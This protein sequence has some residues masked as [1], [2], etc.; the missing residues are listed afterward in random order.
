[1]AQKITKKELTQPDAFQLALT[2]FSDFASENKPKIYIS[3]GI[4]LLII[5]LSAGLYLYKANNEKN[6]QALFIKAHLA[7]LKSRSAESPG[8]PNSTKL[9]Q[10][11]VTQYP[12]TNAA[13]MSF[14]R[15]GNFYY[16]MNDIEA[17]IKAY[18]EYLKGSPKDNELTTLVYIGLGYC[19]ESKKDLNKALEYFENAAKTK[20]SSNFESINYR[21]MARI[22]EELKNNEKSIEFYQKALEKT[23]DPAV[24]QLIK[25]K[26]S[27]LS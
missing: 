25:R 20:S 9:Y 23:S 5:L 12:G 1:M 8:D 11:V 19:Y 27:S 22:H 16:Q 2:R 24:E 14:Y 21:N 3:S 4:V 18:Q 26:I 15:L 6:A 17:S 13:L 10:E 7:T